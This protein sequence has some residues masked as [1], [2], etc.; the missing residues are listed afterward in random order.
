[1]SHR[2]S[3]LFRSCL[4]VGVAAIGLLLSQCSKAADTSSDAAGEHVHHAPHGGS[5]VEIG[6]EFAHLELVLD[7]ATGQLTAF[8]LDG[9]AEN[10][11]RL[12]QPSIT[13]HISNPKVD[14]VLQGVASPLTGETL[15]DTSEFVVQNDQ[16][17][18][19][20]RFDGVVEALTIKGGDFN[21]V[22]FTYSRSN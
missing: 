12:K 14:L 22:Q 11:A 18:G 16:L 21:N 17:K 6:E 7:P 1:M 8:A 10:P 9:E 4:I 20:S 13:I 3:A 5:L 19:V 2:I 15:G